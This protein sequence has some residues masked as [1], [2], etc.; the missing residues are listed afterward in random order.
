MT[1]LKHESSVDVLFGAGHDPDTALSGVEIAG[2]GYD[3]DRRPH[4]LPGVNHA[5]FECIHCRPPACV[6]V[7]VCVCMFVCVCVCVCVCVHKTQ[8]A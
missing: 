4:C 2:A 8:R 6:C 5:H 1:H 3:G 7:C